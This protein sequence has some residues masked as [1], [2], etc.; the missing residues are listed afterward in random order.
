MIKAIKIKN[1]KSIKDAQIALP[2]FAMLIGKNGAG[3]STLISAIGFM[4]KLSR[5]EDLQ[6]VATRI[7]PFSKELFF[8]G[9]SNTPCEM[10]F[11]FETSKDIMYKYKFSVVLEVKEQKGR[12]VIGEESLIRIQANN[13]H[14]IFWRNENTVYER[15][16]EQNVTVP[17][18]ITGNKLALS[19]Y[20]NDEV[21]SL[22][23][24]INE[25]II[26]DATDIGRT[27]AQRLIS[28][29]KP[30]VKTIDGLIVS[31]YTKSPKL[32]EDA[33]AAIKQV[34]PDFV[35][36]TV[37]DLGQAGNPLTEDENM[38]Q[39]QPIDQSIKNYFVIWNE[40]TNRRIFSSI[41]MSGGNIRT[42]FLIYNLFNIPEKSFMVVEELENGM[43]LG[44][45]SRLID[46]FRTQSNNRNIQILFTT[47]STEI[48]E[49]VL[50]KETIFSHKEDLNGSLYELITETDA[51]RATIRED[52]QDEEPSVTDLFNSGMLNY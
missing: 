46:E 50:A 41:S 13:P 40:N 42:C 52:L 16:N 30:D 18:K 12:L 39:D 24:K 2:K 21:V 51:Y 44:R 1:F 34:I 33:S 14:Q 31:L 43:H 17:L 45:V 35:A 7:A 48:P 10:E 38:I 37:L 26:V 11:I 27:D 15:I 25:F 20:S 6:D 49:R 23:N 32:F 8:Q 3:K 9:K 28:E 47:H 22:V 5:G 19:T 36:P 4:Q 29:Q